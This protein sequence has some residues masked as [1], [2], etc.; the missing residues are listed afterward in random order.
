L[1]TISGNG[2][3]G[4]PD[5]CN[6][7]APGISRGETEDNSTPSPAP[8]A[9]TNSLSEGASK[10]RRQSLIISESDMAGHPSNTTVNEFSTATEH[11]QP[12]NVVKRFN[13][14]LV[15]TYTGSKKYP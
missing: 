8:P 13:A 1:Q 7:T 6:N 3:S 9:T 12:D 11:Y 2:I 5:R 4:L 15:C 14:N 10:V